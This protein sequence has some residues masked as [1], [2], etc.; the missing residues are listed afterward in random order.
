MDKNWIDENG[1]GHVRSPEAAGVW[2]QAVMVG[3]DFEADME[4]Q[5]YD[6]F[7]EFKI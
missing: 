7:Q 3:S 6:D 2:S 5:E 1:N 4:A